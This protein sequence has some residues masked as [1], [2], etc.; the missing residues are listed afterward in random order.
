MPGTTG[1]C[2]TT[3]SETSSSKVRNS[4]KD[5]ASPRQASNLS[6]SKLKILRS[7][8]VRNTCPIISK[9]CV[10]AD[11]TVYS[12]SG[13][14]IDKAGEISK[15]IFSDHSSEDISVLQVETCLKPSSKQ[16]CTKL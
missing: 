2:P 3:N 9:S 16:A 11:S 12:V 6:K 5:S 13:L 14:S 8:M 15:Q 7:S 10:D 1:M 4:Y